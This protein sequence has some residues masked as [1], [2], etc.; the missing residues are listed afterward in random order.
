MK[1]SGQAGQP[2]AGFRAAQWRILLA[3]MFCYLFF[4]L[5]FFFYF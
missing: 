5:Y 2:Q 4:Y 1:E 3:T